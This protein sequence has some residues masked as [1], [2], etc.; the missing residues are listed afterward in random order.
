[1]VTKTGSLN[2]VWEL[3]LILCSPTG[4]DA[5]W[6]LTLGLSVTL[7]VYGV[8]NEKHKDS[9]IDSHVASKEHLHI[10]CEPLIT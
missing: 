10:N 2:V 1:M 9:K 5:I 8:E 7:V 3:F 6:T 4:Q